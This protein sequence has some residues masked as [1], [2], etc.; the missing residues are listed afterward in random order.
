MGT[1]HNQQRNPLFAWIIALALVGGGCGAA[2]DAAAPARS[3]T[4]SGDTRPPAPGGGLPGSSTSPAGPGASGPTSGAGGST[5]AGASAPLP[6]PSDPGSSPS[7]TA[8]STGAAGASGSAPPPSSTTPPMGTPP[9]S[10]PPPSNQPQS[11]L[12]TAGTWDD[13]LNF[14]FFQKYHRRMTALQTPGLLDAPI[15][16]RLM[17]MVTDAAGAALAGARVSV[18]SAGK[19]IA[20]TQTGADGRA[21]FFPNWGGADAAASIEIVAEANTIRKSITATVGTPLVTLPL[22]TTSAPVAALDAAIVIDTTGS[23]GD[24]INYLTAEL[25]NISTAIKELYPNVSQRWAFVAYKDYQDEYVTKRFDFV[26]DAASFKNSFAT[27]G[28]G[29]GGDFEEAPERGLADMNTLA[30]R[31]GAVAR[32][33]FWVGDA[34]HHNQHAVDVLSALRDAK[35]KGIHVYPVSASGTDD[36][37]EFSMRV[38]AMITGGRYIF[39]SN[40]SGI[41]GDHKEP[42]IPC[43]RVTTLQ[44]AMLRMIQIELTGKQVEPSAADVLR[45]GGNPRDGRCKLSDGQEVEVL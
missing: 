5:S 40:D 9:V 2:V 32:V 15:S 10:L 19:E 1:Q 36:R 22:G 37:L 35:G 16:D 45:T 24:E 4:A 21:L 13:N 28:A 11:G 18:I 17:V 39:L 38:G 43:Y 6:S 30:W 26:S 25:L 23:M 7:P 12:L 33:A 29:G 20:H 41:G 42:N 31:D 27:L 14:D 44:K 34:P 8:P 3:E